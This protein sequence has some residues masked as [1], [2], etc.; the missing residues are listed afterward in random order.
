MS[1]LKN[2]IMWMNKVKLIVLVINFKIQMIKK[3]KNNKLTMIFNKSM[4][5]IQHFMIIINQQI[6]VNNIKQ[7]NSILMNNQ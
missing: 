6:K 1:F 4:T 7:F 3:N 5:I 2:A